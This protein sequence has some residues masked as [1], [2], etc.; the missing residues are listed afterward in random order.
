MSDRLRELTDEQLGAALATLDL[1]WPEHP[2]LTGDVRTAIRSNPPATVVRLPRR[3]RTKVLL[4]AAAAL[5]LLAGAAVAAKL[6]I[7]LGAVVVR[8]PDQPGT[9]PSSSPAPY[10]EPISLEAAA[11]LLGADVPVPSSLGAPDRIWADRVT[12]DAGEVVRVTLAWRPRA[13]LPAMAGSRFGAVLM[14]FEGD[15]ELASKEL[16][17]QTGTLEGAWVGNIEAL[18]TTGVHALDLLTDDGPI[19]VRVDGNVLLWRDG[20]LTFRLET[21][22]AKRRAE[23]IAESI[24]GTP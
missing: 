8:V 6:V 23:A 1:D 17:Q 2:E 20:D 9:L 22:L 12:T 3:R 18:W 10:G 7:D 4:I 16:H 15:V 14:R 5:F 19:S 13:G 21:A 24:S 11:D